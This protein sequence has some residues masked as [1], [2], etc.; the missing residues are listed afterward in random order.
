MKSKTSYLRFSSL[1]IS[2]FMTLVLISILGIF[3]LIQYLQMQS[4]LEDDFENI[5]Q[6]DFKKRIN[7][8]KTLLANF[9]RIRQNLVNDLS[10][11]SIFTQSV[12]QPESMKENL[13]DYMEDLKIAGQE[14]QIVLL[15]FEGN[16]I[17]SSQSSPSF[18]YKKR[19]WIS[20]MIEGEV[21]ERFDVNQANGNYYMTFATSIKFNEVTE[22]VLLLEIPSGSLVSNYDWSE[23]IEQERLELYFEN[24]MFFSLGTVR[25]GANQT[26]IELPEYN[27]SLNGFL[28]NR[29]LQKTKK[30]ILL[31]MIMTTVL[32]TATVIFI[33]S[34]INRRV[35]ID[36]IKELRKKTNL[37]A[38]GNFTKNYALHSTSPIRELISLDDDIFS[39]AETIC[40]R[41]NSLQEAKHSLENR[42][43]ERTSELQKAAKK[44]LVATQAKSDFL[45]NMSHEIRTPLNGVIG[46]T[47]L[48]LNSNL[49]REQRERI[50][51]I[52]R[53][54]NS[55]LSLINDI[56][57]FSK[58]E[59]GKLDIE[60]ISFD[61]DLLVS[62]IGSVFSNQA[63]AK[64]LEFVCPAN[65]MINA[66][67]FLGDPNR[68][69]Q[70]LSN[71]IGN[72][73]KFTEEGS[74]RV[75][76]YIRKTENK[77][78]EIY[79]CVSDTGIGIN[80]S[81]QNNLFERFTQAD[82]S[83][84][85]RF[86]GTGLGLPI[87]KQLVT[88]MNGDIGIESENGKG[89]NIWFTV[90]LEHSPSEF[91]TESFD[92]LVGTRILLY[93]RS[94]AQSEYMRLVFSAWKMEYKIVECDL[95]YKSA[96]GNAILNNKPF[97]YFIIDLDSSFN[98]ESIL[99]S[100]NDGRGEYAKSNLVLL[101]PKT[102]RINED[103]KEK[104]GFDNFLPKP[105]NQPVLYRKLI[106]IINSMKSDLN[107]NNPVPKS[108]LENNCKNKTGSLA[109]ILVVEDNNINQLVIQGILEEFGTLVDLAC[110]GEEA[111]SKFNLNTY[112]LIFMDCQMPVLDGFK[113][114]RKIR[115]SELKSVLSSRVPIVALTANNM[116]GD[117]EKCIQAG[118]DDFIAKPI[119][120]EMVY[121]SLTKWLSS[122]S[123]H[124][125]I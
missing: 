46:M 39:M 32:V 71:L 94:N 52:K 2:R 13:R 42:V 4:I 125:S 47:H 122:E 41:E 34:L 105:I 60:E 40:D 72:A 57:D 88:L 108:A 20:N 66:H 107:Q 15:D 111:I 62:D 56:L 10:E 104:F 49:S 116:V 112:D 123:W 28:D 77:S 70:I 82:N 92:K 106:D 79:F 118:M 64:H 36:P 91:T 14:V 27:V 51:I 84:T 78:S 6:Q 26:N 17:H 50:L 63:D 11:Q 75:E 67:E 109:K 21:E 8:Y 120:P 76:Y 124:N 59:A 12:L 45:A 61:L 44:A 86:G 98:I 22:G 96:L 23:D 9:I 99:T 113:A 65:L 58:I 69:K 115:E 100:R 7:N 74:V 5:Q 90:Q 53:S 24:N 117:R 95:E 110:N 93:S 101:T 31:K 48:L 83:T 37:V 33:L 85:R 54:G 43:A 30:S 119:E 16:I 103:F 81:T 121:D 73:L 25:T 114:T 18:D 68:I 55:L 38:K 97:D 87:C 80:S 102:K 19:S 1:S 35:F 89:T 3:G 29:E